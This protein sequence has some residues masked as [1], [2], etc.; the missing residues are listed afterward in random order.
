MTNTTCCGGI[1]REDE[2]SEVYPD[3]AP[4]RTKQCY[5]GT[6]TSSG[7]DYSNC[8]A[9]C[10][11]AV[12]GGGTCEPNPIGG[13]CNR[14][15][16]ESDYY[17]GIS[18]APVNVD[19]DYWDRVEDAY[20]NRHSQR[21]SDRRRSDRRRDERE[22]LNILAEG[23]IMREGR[24]GERSDNSSG[25]RDPV[26]DMITNMGVALGVVIILLSIIVILIKH[27]IIKFK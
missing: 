22:A 1:I 26:S 16:P 20:D 24:G 27:R 2:A 6:A 19:Q 14:D 25:I 18:G 11:N 12:D 23:G 9:N 21:R 3:R 13:Y 7:F 17:Y 8:N 15:Q 5:K 4:E 10:C